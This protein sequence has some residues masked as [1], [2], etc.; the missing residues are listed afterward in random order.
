ML[1]ALGPVL[2]FLILLVGC[3]GP[4][5]DPPKSGDGP[6][7][8][9]VLSSTIG[10][11]EPCGCTVDLT[12]GGIDRLATV[13]AAERA[14]GPTA[15]LL[16]GPHLFES[17]PPT[18]RIPQDE[19]K[20]KL[21]ARS[22]AQ[23]G[24][25][26]VVPSPT[27]LARG[28]AFYDALRANWAPPDV[29]VNVPGGAGRIITVG[30][31]KI[32]LLGVVSPNVEVPA[33]HSNDPIDATTQAAAK[34]REQ[35]AQIV[36]GMGVMP[37]RQLRKLAKKVPAV[38]LWLLGDHPSETSIN[39]P[40]GK[41]Y[42]LEAGDRARNLGR[43]VLLD[44][45][46]PGRL[47]NP[48]GDA[49]RARKRLENKLKMRESMFQRTKD[50]TLGAQ[51]A[52]LRTQLAALET[53]I[54]TGKR[55]EYALIPISKTIT[56]DPTIKT[57]LAAYNTELK[58]INLA[59]AGEVPPVPEG[60]SGYTGMQACVDCHEEAMAVYQ[61]TPH[62]RAWQTIVDANKT[63]DTECVGCHV[64][65]WR[66]PGGSV[67]GKTERLENV[68]CEVCHGP[69]EKHVDLGGDENWTR[70]KVPESVCKTCHNSHHSP[71]FDYATYL[72]HVL[73]PG[74]QRRVD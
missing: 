26:A 40:V 3:G 62:A 12:L 48:T 30:G 45:S 54:T 58:A 46:G 73:G 70:R 41:A 34:L 10:Y 61:S 56:P 36:V 20:A 13:V 2:L 59:A 9:L 57:W 25:D 21:I 38:D 22:L 55:F 24:V 47:S 43:V 27:E 5:A 69:G 51:L 28:R 29:T 42:L 44:A 23:I 11:V 63:Y 4:P 16:L 14:Q 31:I 8:L 37:R 35:G 52:E 71:K 65:G 15:V 66:Q 67:L 68:Q 53:P 50:P 1:N 64:T 72:P 60:K 32:G 6:P 39:S 19:A 17:T 74:H 49:K 18:E 33:G 7:R